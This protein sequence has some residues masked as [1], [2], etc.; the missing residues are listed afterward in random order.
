MSDRSD[1]SSST[2]SDSDS[3]SEH[4]T[5]QK[6]NKFAIEFKCK[7]ITQSAGVNKTEIG[8]STGITADFQVEYAF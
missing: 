2:S 6:R 1:S 3:P 8:K 4:T 5:A 7:V